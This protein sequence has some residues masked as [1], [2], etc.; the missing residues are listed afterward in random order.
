MKQ[1]WS[2]IR[3]T[4]Q[5][6]SLCMIQTDQTLSCFL[7]LRLLPLPPSLYP[8]SI[9]YNTPTTYSADLSSERFTQ[10]PLTLYPRARSPTTKHVFCF[11]SPLFIPPSPHPNKN[12]EEITFVSISSE[13]YIGSHKTPLMLSPHTLL[14]DPSFSPPAPPAPLTQ[15]RT[16]SHLLCLPTHPVTWPLLPLLPLLPL[17]PKQKLPVTYFVSVPSEESFTRFAGHGVEVVPQSSVPTHPVTWPLLPLLPLSPKQKLPVTY[18]VSPHTLLLDPSCPSCPSHPNKNSLSLTLSPHTPCYL[19][20]PAPLTQTKTPCHLLC[21]PTH[22]VTWPLL[23]LLPLSPNQEPPVTYFVS[24]P[25]EESFTRLA[26]HGVEVV[27]QRSVPT[28]PVTWPLLPLL[29][30]LSLLPLLPLS[31]KQELPVTYFVSV[32]SE[33]SFT[34][35]AGHGVEVVPQYPVSTHTVTWPLLPLLPLLSLLPL[36]PKQELPVTYFVSV[37]SEESFTR[38]AGHGVEVVPQRPVATHQTRLVLLAAADR[39]HRGVRRTTG[40][41][42]GSALYF[43]LQLQ[44]H[45]VLEQTANSR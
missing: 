34:R 22:P 33:E 8:P 44:R 27:P 45:R 43:P 41:V 6:V 9:P 38:L 2:G 28:H 19:T 26:G 12:S 5:V 29:P 18:F 13:R 39:G 31:P 4:I 11:S 21:L 40:H 25:S 30:L 23:P 10:T 37:P 20:P 15:T 3:N 14:L 42:A 35:F 32:P 24:V 1:H 7:N 16:P 36:S 17:S